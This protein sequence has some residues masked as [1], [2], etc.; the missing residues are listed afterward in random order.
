[1]TKGFALRRKAGRQSGVRYFG[2]FALCSLSIVLCAFLG[3][4]IALISEHPTTFMNPSEFYVTFAMACLSVFAALFLVRREFRI[5]FSWPWFLLFAT[6][7]I[8]NAIGTFAFGTHFTGTTVYRGDTYFYDLT[9]TIEERIRYVLCFALACVNFYLFFAVFPKVLPHTRWLRLFCWAAVLLAVAAIVYSLIVEWDLYCILFDPARP[10]VGTWI[11]SFTNNENTFGFIILNAIAAVCVLHNA[12]SRFRY[13]VLILALGLFQLFGLSATSI[14]CTWILIV[15]YGSYRYALNVRHKPGRST[16]TLLLLIGGVIAITILIFT[17]PF[18]PGSFL[19]KIHEEIA[20]YFGKR[21]RTFVTRVDTWNI[22]IQTLTD[23]KLGWPFG[24]GDFQSRIYLAVRHVPTGDGLVI[25]AAHSSALQSLVDGGLVGLAIHLIA[26]GYILFIAIKRLSAHSKI[27]MVMLL[28]FVTMLLHGTME[29]SNFLSMDI[30][31]FGI[32]VQFVLPLEVETFHASHSKLGDYLETCK[33]DAKK[34]RYRYETSPVRF[35]KLA[36]LFLTP[37]MILGI[38]VGAFLQSKGYPGMDFDWSCYL[39]LAVVW[40]LAPLGYL[41]IGT[42]A[43]RK[44]ATFWFTVLVLAL[45][46]GGIGLGWLSVWVSRI[47]FIAALLLCP[48]PFVIHAKTASISIS[49]A[50][51]EAYLPHF[52]IGFSLVGLSLLCLLIPAGEASLQV[53]FSLSFAVVLA[54]SCL[55]SFP[56]KLKLGYPLV[57]K[58]HHVDARILAKSLLREERLA[59]K[60][61]RRL[62]PGYVPPREKRIYLTHPW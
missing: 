20:S 16:I 22:V 7:A 34:V 15:A 26:L 57:E 49:D 12:N 23:S 41:G 6:L 58:L 55:I 52:L 10:V 30:K 24:I 19:A 37:A 8:G 13:W 11:M 32:L 51:L 48:L 5:P 17:D 40:M 46:G 25:Y 1:M 18:G 60:Q 33:G 44:A 53:V 54:Y 62:N 38:A 56:R 4:R 2:V 42:M 3:E 21:S 39:L 28:C 45:L 31:G 59:V 36:F 43:K 29:S 47:A 14:V 35:C 9:L 27:G 50:F 61:L